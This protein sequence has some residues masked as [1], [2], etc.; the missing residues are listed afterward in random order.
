MEKREREAQRV[1]KFFLEK[2]GYLL[3]E[4]SRIAALQHRSTA[5][6]QDRSTAALTFI[7]TKIAWLFIRDLS[8]KVS[9]S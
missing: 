5:A 8:A 9:R 4:T 3:I 6:P 2:L 7:G 1:K